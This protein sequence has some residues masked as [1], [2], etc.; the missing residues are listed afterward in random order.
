MRRRVDRLI[1]RGWVPV[2]SSIVGLGVGALLRLLAMPRAA[3]AVWAAVALMALVPST[4]SMVRELRKRHAGV[5]IVATLALL[6]SLLVGE[7][8]AGA[9]IALMLASGRALEAY[10]STRA[11]RELTALLTRTPTS[12][13]R[14]EGDD[15]VTVGVD[16]VRP[17]DVIVMASGEVVPVD[18]VL[19]T[20]AV[21]DESALTGESALVDRCVG[22]EIRSGGVNAGGPARL[23]ATAI[24]AESTYAGIVRLVREAEQGRAPMLR[25]ADRFALWFA[26]LTITMAGVAAV[27]ARD[28]VRAV[29]VLVVATP[30]PLILAAP[31]AL[32]GGLSRAA[33]RGVVVKNG[34]ALEALG[35][36]DIVLFDKTGTLTE[37]RA[38]VA[39][40]ETD[41]RA[42]PDDILRRAA[43]L[44]QLSGHAL[45]APIVRA[46][47]QRGLD[48][49]LPTDVVEDP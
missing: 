39:D 36:A 19:V 28:P 12:V 21:L 35:R 23:R 47:R 14:L 45:A 22:D 18:G 46:A 11:K 17:N 44:D 32:V 6:G 13:H 1:K 7:F 27:V 43:S 42:D 8:L 37:G 20:D 31:V 49:E 3:D 38:H 5:D 4:L 34:A 10:A 29:A 25:L 24:A 15:V 48:L 2:V 41:G 26:L 16:E 9:V 30:C 33:R 40:V